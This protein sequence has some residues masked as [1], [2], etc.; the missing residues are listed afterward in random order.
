MG[1]K[2]TG[3]TVI[4][5]GNNC[6]RSSDVRA[7]TVTE[8]EIEFRVDKKTKRQKRKRYKRKELNRKFFILVTVATLRRL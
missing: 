6:P 2:T 4:P 3:C 5:V 1:F 7:R 8:G